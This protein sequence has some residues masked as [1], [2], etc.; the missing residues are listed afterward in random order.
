[1]KK[2]NILKSLA[3]LALAFSCTP[4]EFEEITS[5][6]LKRCLEPQNLS[7]KIDPATGEDAIFSWDV[8]KD[9]D[10][11]NLVIYTD[12]A[13]TAKAK[14]L[15]VLAAE[16]P[17][18]IHLTAD[19]EYWF[20]VRAYRL[21]EPDAETGVAL[22]KEDTYSNWAVYDGS[23]KTYAVKD[24]LFME[25]T[26]RTANS[27][28]FAW[29]KDVT[30]YKD[31]T[32][33]VASP[34]K[35]GDKVTKDLSTAEIN[36]AAATVDG[37]AAS[38]EYQ[39]VLYYMSASRGAVDTW[40]L[41]EAGSKTVISTEAELKAAVLDGDYYLSY[42]DAPISMG[43][44]KPTGSLSIVG[45]LGP[46]GEK[47]T[48]VGMIE[49]AA[50]LADNATLHFENI[51]F[52]GNAGSRIVNHTGGALNVASIK[53]VNCEIT[54]F[55]AGFFYGNA[56]DLI[57]IGEF[58][59]DTCDMYGIPGSG[60]DAFDIRK[61]SEVETV[62]FVNNTMQDGIRTLFRI[63]ASDEIKIGTIDFENNTVK[64]IATID[65]GNNRGIFAVRVAHN[66]ILKSNV[67]LWEDGGKAADSADADKAQLFQNNAGT[68]EPTFTAAE[69]N[70][71]YANGK[72]FF[73]KISA[74]VAGV[75]VLNEDPCYNSKG[76]F[77]QLA[78]EDLIKA[79]AGASKWWISYV[80]K[81]ED[82]TQNVL[83]GAHTWNLQDATLF[84]GEVK[85]SRVRDELLLVGTEAT[86]LNAD[87]AIN[88]LGAS[89]LTRKGVPTEGYAAFKVNT[90]GSVDLELANGG[91][92]SI[93]V[94]LQ[95]DN[96]FNVIGGA[97]ATA[98]A[99]V[100]KVVIPAVS[101]EG[102]V[103]LYSTGAISLKK[104][105]WSLDVLAGN[106]VLATPKPVAEP[107]TLTEGDATEVVFTWEAIDNAA[108]YVPVFNKKSYPAQTELSFTVAAEDIATLKAGLYGFSVQAKPRE[109]DIY[110]VDS[111]K[112]SASIAIQPKGGAG[113]MVEVT[114][115]WDFS[116]ADW[117][118]QFAA[119]GAA[120]TD[121]TNW[122]LTYD[123]LTIFS[124]AK[125]K[126]NTTFFQ[127]GGK[128]SLT[129]RYLKFTAPEQGTLK[130][131]ASN[132]GSSEDLTR[133]VTVNQNGEETS[134]AGGV[135]SNGAPAEC[136]FSVMA[137]DVY[138]YASGN[139]LRFYKVEFTFT[140][141]GKQVIEKD[142]DFSAAD[143]QEQFAAL[144]GANTDITNWN[145]TY[146]D[147][148]I[149]ST[150]K[151]K[152]NTTF[153]QWGGK[154][155]LTDRYI[156]YTAPEQGTIKVYASN[157]GSSED[158]TRMVTVNQN[159]EETSVA[160][161]VPSNGDPAECEF[162]VMAGD[163]YIYCTGNALRFYRIT[164][165]NQ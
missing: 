145:L 126:Y 116:A 61:T 152:Y 86:P 143:W 16:V 151:S 162:S 64:N 81:T 113:E 1:M 5:L 133:M 95:D 130:V 19:Q 48:V 8:N 38:T 75:K 87:G 129:D 58:T 70:Y 62:R 72:D 22:A 132:T 41:A 39:F 155:S 32:K 137:G 78:N 150:A 29:S 149:V 139:A 138:I 134:I 30:D 60:G 35:G 45:E 55:L 115:S 83:A 59:F 2:F 125:S 89:A 93:V 107:V 120:N 105:A 17:Y 85:N 44:A 51:K 99:G 6:E 15:E 159:G 56:N 23:E 11:Y 79:K 114:W 66:M 164:Y 140:T 157:T 121:I 104:L 98:N 69:N 84:A 27:V 141:G 148:T 24:N 91:A 123:N 40:T 103:Y 82:L 26:A 154:G 160:G 31:V 18:T 100:Q 10:A 119:L 33:I 12:E 50:G 53:F 136:E 102:M 71:S 165:T 14:D 142:W 28:S 101:G 36:A 111:E 37:L 47:P 25:V 127:W 9:A 109:D 112:G 4:Q 97:M 76:N 21:E 118:E 96:G 92:S 131:W 57:K 3:V 135:P 52:D 7:L 156:K 73:T 146:D 144:G 106:K 54:N 90:P 43:T 158:L 108:S 63:D 80:E 153:F 94:A 88:F 68:V 122:N 42:S 163:V 13:M 65:D 128:G 117:Q 34:V 20:K 124:T 110:Y 77:F 49:L 67:F 161:G 147:I 46:N 74:Q